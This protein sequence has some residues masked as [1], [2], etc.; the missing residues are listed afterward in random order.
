MVN[1]LI[2]FKGYFNDDFKAMFLKRIQ[3]LRPAFY[4][5]NMKTFDEHGNKLLAGERFEDDQRILD[6]ILGGIADLYGDKF[7]WPDVTVEN[8]ERH[9]MDHWI[10]EGLRDAAETDYWYAYE[11]DYGF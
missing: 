8:V 7:M 11:K 10:K 9:H 6:R 1:G 4:I 3:E 2:F 5:A